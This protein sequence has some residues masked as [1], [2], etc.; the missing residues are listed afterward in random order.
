M[1]HVFTP[2]G[3]WDLGLESIRDPKSAARTILLLRLPREAILPALLLVSVLSAIAQALLQVLTPTPVSPPPEPLFVIGPGVFALFLATTAFVFSGA[4]T[5]C[6]RALGGVGTFPNILILLTWLQYIQFA[7][8]VVQLVLIFTMPTLAALLTLVV[9]VLMVYVTV[10]F[11]AV[12]HDFDGFGKPVL[13]FLLAG[14][15]L[16]LIL[17]FLVTLSGVPLGA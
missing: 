13:T 11:I 10:N 14:V 1:E 2:R 16:I 7:F 9:L 6:G 4:L 8:S 17:S 5:V 15:G 12:V 3:L